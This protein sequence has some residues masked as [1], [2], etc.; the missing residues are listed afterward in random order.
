MKFCLRARL[1]CLSLIRQETLPHGHGVLNSWW[2]LVLAH[3]SFSEQWFT[4]QHRQVNT[5]HRNAL[6]SPDDIWIAIDKHMHSSYLLTWCTTMSEVYANFFASCHSG[7]PR[8]VPSNSPSSLE[9]LKL[10]AASQSLSLSLLKPPCP[11][12]SPCWS[13]QQR[14]PDAS[15]RF[16]M[17]TDTYQVS[18][19]AADAFQMPQSYQQD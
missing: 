19:M 6:D 8:A 11:S 3:H 12:C 18:Q 16:P 15:S 10:S 13:L 1:A 5:C 4:N 9:S 14:L 17:Y 7:S 2:F